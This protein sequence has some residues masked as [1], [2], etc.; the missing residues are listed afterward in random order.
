MRHAQPLAAAGLCYGSTDLAAQPAATQRAADQL[1]LR[2]PAGLGLRVS[3]LRRCQQLAQALQARRP[4]LRPETDARLREMH[5]GAW[6]G[7]RWADIGRDEFD[8]WL[9]DFAAAPPG[10]AGEPVQALMARVAGAWDD[11]R[12][13]GRDA[14][15]IT[16][17]GVMRAALLLARGVRL[18]ARASDWPA[19]ELPFG[20][21]LVLP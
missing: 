20:Q 8:A 16:H 5:F 7:R 18:P 15:W 6:E 14:A 9:G 21:V 17:A 12:A 4:D 2:L 11:W 1:A 13:G 10:G 19:D 3:P